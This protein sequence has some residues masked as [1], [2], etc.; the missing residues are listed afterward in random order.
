MSSHSDL[1]T[2]ALFVSTYA[3]AFGSA[4]QMLIEPGEFLSF[5]P[6]HFNVA[7][8]GKFWWK[9]SS[10]GKCVAGWIAILS[11]WFWCPVSAINILFTT[12]LATAFSIVITGIINVYVQSR[13]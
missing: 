2:T 3:T 11:A 4:Y 8:Y 6:K 1:L 7:G 9:L 10:C 12:A 5:I 13:T